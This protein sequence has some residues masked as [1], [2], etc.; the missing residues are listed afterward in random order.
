MTRPLLVL[1]F[2]MVSAPAL[3]DIP[4]PVGW[5]ESCTV[6][7][8]AREGRECRDCSTYHGNP[9]TFCSDQVGAGFTKVCRSRGSSAW[10]EVWCREASAQ[11]PSAEPTTAMT[12]A[13]AAAM[14][15][16]TVST[17]TTPAPSPP[18]SNDDCSVGYASRGSVMPFVLL[19][20]LAFAAGR[21]RTRR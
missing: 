10:T 12:D 8:Q 7:M 6:A 1:L 16:A 19:V 5:V 20:G 14:N 15:E 2:V 3:A 13:P 4:P 11:S 9:P 17:N 21:R 18:A